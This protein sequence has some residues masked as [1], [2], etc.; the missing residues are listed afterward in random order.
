MFHVRIRTLSSLGSAEDIFLEDL[1]G[2]IFS[3]SATLPGRAV[4]IGFCEEWGNNP[5]KRDKTRW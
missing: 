2:S 4:S 5:C 1:C 3:F